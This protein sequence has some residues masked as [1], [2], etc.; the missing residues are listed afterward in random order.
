VAKT[1][2]FVELMNILYVCESVWVRESVR[3]GGFCVCVLRI[4]IMD[5]AGGYL[6]AI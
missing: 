3:G 6:E 1:T 4:P 5:I 2:M